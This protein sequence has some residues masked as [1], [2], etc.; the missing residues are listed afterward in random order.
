MWY[1]GSNVYNN[2]VPEFNVYEI[3][4]S[5][6]NI[7]PNTSDLEKYDYFVADVNGGNLFKVGN[8][9]WLA[10]MHKDQITLYDK[11]LNIIKTLNGPDGYNIE[12]ESKT[13]NISMPFVV[14][15]SEKYYSSY[16]Y[17]TQTDK[18]I[19]IIYEH[20]TGESFNPEQLKPIEIFKFDL[21][22]KPIACFQLDNYA[23]HIS[24]DKKEENLYAT[25]RNSYK[26]P[27][28]FVKYKLK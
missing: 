17:W 3:K 16:K 21:E 18:H 22:G 23:Y 2:Q 28:K 6:Q 24:V 8:T 9:V 25:I 15:K 5:K 7:S 27:A 19:Y 1:C 26:E 14:F 13:S 20:L 11:S 12:Y 4:T 10:D